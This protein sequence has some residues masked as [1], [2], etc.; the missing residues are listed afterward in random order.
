MNSGT[1]I[2]LLRTA[3]GISQVC[4]SERIGVSR[5]YLSQ[6]ENNRK[7]PGL[8]FFKE[9]S[10]TFSIPL[11]LLLA[12]EEYSNSEIYDELKKILGDILAAK[13]KSVKT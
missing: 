4:L 9:V 3:E 7:Q 2:K 13:I 12:D 8:S 6:I 11:V 1:I 10:K 5:A